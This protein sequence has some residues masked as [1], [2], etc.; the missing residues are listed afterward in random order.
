MAR[1]RFGPFEFDGDTRELSQDGA[2]VRLQAQPAQV[3]A[4]LLARPGEVVTRASLQE[5]LWGAETHVDFDNSLNFCMSQLRTALGNS[6]DAPS[7]IKTLPKRGYP[8]HSSRHGGDAPTQKVVYSCCDHG[9]P[10]G[11]V[12][13]FQLRRSVSKLATHRSTASAM[14]YPMLSS[15]SSLPHLRASSTS[16]AMP[17]FFAKFETARTWR[18]LPTGCEPNTS[19]SAKCSNRRTRVAC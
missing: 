3:L 6:A 14:G 9:L 15:R 18:E 4:A 8:V 16:S 11:T 5:V 7:Y 13:G 12:R 17:L 2:I 10:S 19:S 1:L